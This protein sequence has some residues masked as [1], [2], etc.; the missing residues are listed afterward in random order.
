LFIKPL[1]P[2]DSAGQGSKQEAAMPSLW[3][4]KKWLKHLNLCMGSSP[5]LFFFSIIPFHEFL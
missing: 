4:R 5:F 1:N 3:P 2:I